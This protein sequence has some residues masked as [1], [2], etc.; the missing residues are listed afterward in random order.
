MVDSKVRDPSDPRY[1]TLVVNAQ[2]LE[3]RQGGDIQD[4]NQFLIAEF[5]NTNSA[6]S[7]ALSMIT[8]VD[9][10]VLMRAAILG[11]TATI[12]KLLN[13][14]H[15]IKLIDNQSTFLPENLDQLMNR[16]PEDIT[17]FSVEFV[18]TLLELQP[19][20][21]NWT[22]VI[23]LE[24]V[25]RSIPNESISEE[26]KLVIAAMIDADLSTELQSVKYSVDIPTLSTPQPF[27]ITINQYKAAMNNFDQS[28]F[29]ILSLML[30]ESQKEFQANFRKNQALQESM[31]LL[32]QNYF[33]L[34]FEQAI[35]DIKNISLRYASNEIQELFEKASLPKQ[36][37]LVDPIASLSPRVFQTRMAQLG[38]DQ[39]SPENFEKMR[40]AVQFIADRF[41]MGIRVVNFIDIMNAVFLLDGVSND[42]INYD[43]KLRISSSDFQSRRPYYRSYVLTD[44]NKNIIDNLIS[45]QT[46]LLPMRAPTLDS[47]TSQ[48]P[49]HNRPVDKYDADPDHPLYNQGPFV[50]GISGHSFSMI[51]AAALYYDQPIEN[52]D[53]SPTEVADFFI[54]AT[55]LTYAMRGYHSFREM[56]DVFKQPNVDL[57]FQPNFLE[58]FKFN[59]ELIHAAMIEAAGYTLAICLN[60]N[61]KEQIEQNTTSSP[62]QSTPSSSYR[63]RT[64]SNANSS[65]SSGTNP[66][67]KKNR[68]T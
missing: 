67:N 30:L 53:L 50:K 54:R 4:F 61:L 24:Q 60:Q 64:N 49:Q 57:I 3:Q 29:I 1:Q 46:G 33:N 66:S 14:Y 58:K 48:D 12:L 22:A 47:A 18:K 68:L 39:N 26:N 34:N 23:W 32:Y 38:L 11:E 52:A 15:V 63:S 43:K 20:Q 16:P 56:M 28:D 27:T 13:K 44:N 21:K 55:I 10:L 25:L 42:I 5:Q 40:K 19:N 6:I 41:N 62:S 2:P 45:M 59:P 37:K 36:L 35:T 9:R 7:A 17:Q 31:K 8:E 65:S 51:A